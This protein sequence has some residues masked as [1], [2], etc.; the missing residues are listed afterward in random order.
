SSNG[1]RV[2][3][4]TDEQLCDHCQGA[5]HEAQSCK[6]EASKDDFLLPGKHCRG[7]GHGDHEQKNCSINPRSQK[8]PKKKAFTAAELDQL[9][10]LFRKKFGPKEIPAATSKTSSPSAKVSLSIRQSSGQGTIGMPASSSNPDTSSPLAREDAETAQLVRW[11]LAEREMPTQPGYNSQVPLKR[12][13]IRAN[14]FEIKLNPKIV[15]LWKYSI[16]IQRSDPKRTARSV[17]EMAKETRK[18]KRETK[19]FLI[20]DLLG[21]EIPPDHDDWA[22][23]Y[24]STIVSARPLYSDTSKLGRWVEYQPSGSGNSGKSQPTDT[25]KNPTLVTA[26]NEVGIIDMGILKKHVEGKKCLDAPEDLLKLLNIISWKNITKPNSGVGRVG[27]KFYPEDQQSAAEKCKKFSPPER[28]FVRHGFFSSMRPG[29][30]SVYLN[31]NTVTTAFLSPINLHKWMNLTWGDG[32]VSRWQ[33]KLLLKDVR[34]KFDLHQ[35][36]RTWVISD[37]SDK[38]VSQTEFA[39]DNKKTSVSDY[40]R[41]KYPAYKAKS[42][43]LNGPCINVGNP[44]RQIWYPASLLTIMDWQVARES[45]EKVFG[46]DTTVKAATKPPDQNRELIWRYGLPLLG[47]RIDSDFY[48]T[49]GMTTTSAFVPIQGANIPGPRLIYNKDRQ[50]DKVKIIDGEWNLAQQESFLRPRGG[51]HMFVLP[52]T[53]W[54]GLLEQCAGE[55]GRKIE[56][57]RMSPKIN[58][59]WAH[60]PSSLPDHRSSTRQGFRQEWTSTLDTMYQEFKPLLKDTGVVPFLLIVLPRRDIPIYQEIKRWADC[61]VGIP[62]VCVT[63]RKL[64]K[65]RDEKLAANICLKIN[66]KMKGVSHWIERPTKTSNQD[67]TGAHKNTM[68]VGADVTHPGNGLVDCPSMAAVVAT[69]DERSGHYLVSA[70]LQKGKQEYISDLEGMIAERVQA[71]FSKSKTDPLKSSRWETQLPDRILFYRDG[72]S[73]SQYGMVL[74]EEKDQIMRG[75][76]NAFQSLKLQKGSMIPPTGKWHPRLTLIVVSKRHHARFYTDLSL[77]KNLPE[78]TLIDTKVVIPYKWSFYLQSHY[79]K[80]G[81]ARSA[82]YVVVFDDD[83]YNPEDLQRVTNNLCFSSARATKI[84]SVCTPARYADILCDRLRCYMRPALDGSYVIAPPQAVAA[85]GKRSP[86]SSPAR[87]GSSSSDAEPADAEAHGSMPRYVRRYI[88]DPRVWMSAK[89]NRQNPWH[90]RLDDTMFYL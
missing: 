63:T 31:V 16:T 4:R 72:V 66:F 83:N 39:I 79:S 60:S 62:C 70:R 75:C 65:I 29:N 76:Q 24:E 38:K 19:R 84:V 81:T 77:T 85:P 73:E 87:G 15:S 26:I 7:C 17:E 42:A 41:K 3:P 80:L 48:K 5:D 18:I 43:D 51:T 10:P 8:T 58:I 20:E 46:E 89:D 25:P 57:Y 67:S 33:F 54:T 52:L 55:L 64:E 68:V 82:L 36:S 53:P 14:F 59:A 12:G 47:L 78:G 9:T 30:G 37:M 44:N 22:C 45:V 35:P 50:N 23:D 71:W 61:S 1:P 13:Q 88:S 32:N 6:S 21:R 90:P 49:F 27:N 69:H 28:Y 56:R 74:H 40:L 2:Y 34:V 86:F 11:K